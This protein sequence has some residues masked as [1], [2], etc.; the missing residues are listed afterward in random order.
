MAVPVTAS[1]PSCYS[2]R[3]F[4]PIYTNSL[5]G[6]PV[7]EWIFYGY[8]MGGRFAAGVPQEGVRHTAVSADAGI[9][10]PRT[11]TGRR[12]LAQRPAVGPG[13]GG[14]V[15]RPPTGGFFTPLVRA[16]PVR[17]DASAPPA[18]PPILRTRMAWAT[19]PAGPNPCWRF[20]SPDRRVAS[21]AS[22]RRR[23][24][25]SVA[26]GTKNTWDGGNFLCSGGDGDCTAFPKR[27]TTSTSSIP[28]GPNSSSPTIFTASG[29]S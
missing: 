25:I 22:A 19:S 28:N 18:I 1:T 3:I 15:Q 17:G 7:E 13:N 9:G 21:R 2:G 4:W 16:G 24:S 11:G 29:C 26:N 5:Q 27:P 14:P 20:P 23:E 8:S 12:A 6:L 10:F